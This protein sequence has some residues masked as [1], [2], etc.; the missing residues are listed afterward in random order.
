MA[1]TFDAVGVSTTGKAGVTVTTVSLTDLTV[2]TNSQRALVIQVLFLGTAGGGSAPT[3]VAWNWDATGTP[4]ALTQIGTNTT[5]G[6]GQIVQLWGLVNP[7]S[8]NKTLTGTWTNNQE[9]DLQA[10]SWWGVD[11]TGGTTS[12]AHFNSATGSS[13]TPSVTV[14]SAVGN[15][16]MAVMVAGTAVGIN[17]VDNTQTFLYH[18]SGS[19]EGGGNRAAGAASVVLTGTYAGSDLWAIAGVDI[20]A[21]SGGDLS[22]TSIGEPVIST[23][24]F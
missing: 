18:G 10:V 13:A 9:V 2:G 23:A 11:Q 21:A 4:Q 15:A 20:V 8:G 14:T 5:S 1:V 3:G 16:V 6:N 12:F 24:T 19:I 17:S 7:T 22:V